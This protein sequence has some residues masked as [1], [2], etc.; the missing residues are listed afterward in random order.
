MSEKPA[1]MEFS[2]DTRLLSVTRIDARQAWYVIGSD[3]L[4]PMGH[5]L[6]PFAT[7]EDADA[8]LHDHAA[9]RILP[10]GDVT[11]ELLLDL[12]AGRF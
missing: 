2:P 11:Q 4:G 12:D 9:K 5:E 10:F 8:F 3:V 7:L 6:V 1:A